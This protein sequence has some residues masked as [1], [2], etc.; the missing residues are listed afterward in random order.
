MGNGRFLTVLA[1]GVGAARFLQ[2][3]AAV[4]PQEWLR[5]VVNTGDDATFYGLHVSPDIDTILYW[6]SGLADEERG[7]GIRGDTF[8][9]L[10]QL[11]AY[12]HDTWFN[13]GDRDLATHIHRT[14]L[15]GQGKTLSEVTTQM[16]QALGVRAQVLPMSDQPVRTWV[17]TPEGL[18][19][20]Q[21]YFVRRRT[22]PEVRGI[23]FKGIEEARPA[24]GVLEAIQ[25]A[26]GIIVAPSN[27]IIS[28]GPILALPGV[29]AA[30]TTT[31]APVAA[32]SPIVA[33]AAIKGPADRMMRG[34]GLEASALG[35]AKLYRD[36]LDD[37]VLD[38][39]DASLKPH[40]EA[41]GVRVWVTDTIMASRE[42]AVHLAR[43][44]LQA[45]GWEAG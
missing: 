36:F 11:R 17:E 2:G 23:V 39:R 16:C 14:L 8:H 21:E 40:I 20:F 22:E 7:W 43:T 1:G 26:A 12:G 3:L 35:V 10:G 38:Q 15:L 24:P 28:V 29:R 19:P 37:F 34:L 44:V 18:L 27:P 25:Q 33:G 5:I 41:L 42:V 32:V 45:L 9:L 4:F 31:P 13:L 30:L 6:L